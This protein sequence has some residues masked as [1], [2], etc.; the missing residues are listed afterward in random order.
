MDHLQGDYLRVD[1]GLWVGYPW[2][3]NLLAN[4]LPVDNVT[5]PKVYVHDNSRLTIEKAVGY[6]ST[7]GYYARTIISEQT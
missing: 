1:G 3:N 6:G 4:R 2:V 5:Q 7:W